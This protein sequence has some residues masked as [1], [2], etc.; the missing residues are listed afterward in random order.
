MAALKLGALG[1]LASLSMARSILEPKQCPS[2]VPLSCH[3]S[4]AVEDTCCFNSPGGLILLTQF[5][6]TD[7]ATGPDDSWTIHGLW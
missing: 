2:D 5:W 6:D 1:L 3:N 4:T 7:P